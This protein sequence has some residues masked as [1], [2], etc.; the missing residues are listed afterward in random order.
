MSVD[1]HMVR[2]SVPKGFPIPSILVR[3][4]KHYRILDRDF[5]TVGHVI[6]RGWFDGGIFPGCVIEL[7]DEY[8]LKVQEIADEA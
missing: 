6:E 2:L 3:D 8:T 5:R 7:F 1:I 4:G